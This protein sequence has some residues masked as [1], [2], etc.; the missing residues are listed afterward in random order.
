[1]RGMERV[2]EIYDCARQVDNLESLFERVLNKASRNT[3]ATVPDGF[4]YALT[5]ATVSDL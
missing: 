1:L 3:P 2:N 4:A 5:G